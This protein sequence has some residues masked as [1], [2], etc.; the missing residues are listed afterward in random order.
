MRPKKLLP[1]IAHPPAERIFLNG[2]FGDNRTNVSTGVDHA[3]RW[4]N[5]ELRGELPSADCDGDILS[6][7]LFT[8]LVGCPPSR[9]SLRRRRIVA[10]NRRLMRG[11]S[12]SRY[13][14][15]HVAADHIGT[16]LSRENICCSHRI[17][18]MAP[19]SHY[20]GQRDFGRRTP[21]GR[22]WVKMVVAVLQIWSCSS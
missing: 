19:I 11:R 5:S 13:E 10:A 7:E 18:L 20:S 1:G 9:G 14:Y 16:A 2:E 17:D 21:V 6:G 8:R 4:L 3:M 12:G 15:D 22:V